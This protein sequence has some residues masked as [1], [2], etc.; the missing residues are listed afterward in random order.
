MEIAATSSAQTTTQAN[1]KLLRTALDTQ[2]EAAAAILEML[3]QVI[4]IQA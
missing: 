2:V 4:D 3:G 1:V